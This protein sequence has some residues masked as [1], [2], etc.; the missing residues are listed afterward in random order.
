[1]GQI[2]LSGEYQQGCWLRLRRDPLEQLRAYASQRSSTLLSAG[3]AVYELELRAG[4]Q[5]RRPIRFSWRQHRGFPLPPLE[6]AIATTRLGPFVNVS[7]RGRYR[8]GD[9]LAAR[10]LDE[11]VGDKMASQTL[12][13]VLKAIS[14]ILDEQPQP[15]RNTALIVFPAPQPD[16]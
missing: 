5:A 8:F 11:A 1:M 12:R 13:H 3:G 14:L 4:G 9:D 16:R 10:L 7:V 15:D 6:G 2:S